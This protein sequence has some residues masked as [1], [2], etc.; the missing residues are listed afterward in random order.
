M[1]HTFLLNDENKVVAL[2]NPLLD[3]NIKRLYK[4]ELGIDSINHELSEIK[5]SPK[6]LAMG[7][8][9]IGEEKMAK[10][11][12]FN[13]GSKTVTIRDISTSCSCTA[14]WADN[15]TIYPNGNIDIHV[16]CQPEKGDSHFVRYVNVLL[17]DD[18]EIN[19]S[20]SG[21]MEIEN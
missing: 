4:K 13:N 10:F 15:D 18:Q 19:L 5:V 17:N 8:F 6:H 21:F 11:R 2:G 1:Y 7:A 14:A 9:T 16:N 3:P 20:I 12:L